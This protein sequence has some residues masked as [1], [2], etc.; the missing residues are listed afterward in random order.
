MRNL[1]LST[2][3]IFFAFPGKSQNIGMG[4]PT[5]NMPLHV[6][7]PSDTALIQ[8][9]N[10]TTL[11]TNTNVGIGTTNPQ[12]ALEVAGTFRFTNGSQGAGKVLT[13]NGSGVHPRPHH[14]VSLT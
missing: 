8:L 11:A 7:K 3:L 12:T 2:L 6:Y 13:S 4:T 10:G 14:I 5:P 9:E 1:L